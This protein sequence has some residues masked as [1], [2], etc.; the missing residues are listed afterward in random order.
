M[1]TM[2][3]ALSSEMKDYVQ[4]QVAQGG[5]SSVSEYVRALIREDQRRKDE[6]RLEAILLEGMASGPATDMT[7]QDWEDLRRRA[8]KRWEKKTKVR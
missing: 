7:D 8:R 2:N 5:Y 1:E 6:A 3:V 4:T